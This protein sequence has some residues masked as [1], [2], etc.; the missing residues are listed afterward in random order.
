MRHVLT[1]LV[2][3]AASTLVPAMAWAGNQEFAQQIAT[4]L[5]DSGQMK[6]YSIAVKYQ[7]GTAW[8]SGRV[9]S[10]DQVVTAM[11]LVYEMPGVSRVVNDLSVTSPEAS[12]PAPPAPAS[13]AE[14]PTAPS[15]P[16]DGAAARLSAMPW[17]SGSDAGG[18]QAAMLAEPQVQAP[19]APTTAARTPTTSRAKSTPLAMAVSYLQPSGAVAPPQAAPAGPAAPVPSPVPATPVP[20]YSAPV[21]QSAPAPMNYDQ[22]QMPNCAWPSYAAYPNYAGVTYPRQY[23]ATAWPFIGPFYPYPQVP[24][25]WRKVTLSW[26]DGWWWLDF[27]DQPCRSWTWFR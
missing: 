20:A 10:A 4:A 26:D 1:G 13:A 21:G 27:K 6:N 11:R 17:S 16:M 15:P 24:L 2:I 5:R 3:A 19:S 23:S 8:L 7:D 12:V 18:V 14:I 9:A 22:P 25:G